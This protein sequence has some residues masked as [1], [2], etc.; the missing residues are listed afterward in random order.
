MASRR[1]YIPQVDKIYNSVAA[2]AA[3]LGVNA[4]NLGK[5]LS[6]KRKTAGGYS[7]IDASAYSKGGKMVTPNR[8]SLRNKAAKSGVY[9]SAADPLAAKR[10]ELQSLLI[11]TNTESKKIK[12][13]GVSHFATY[14]NKALNFIDDIGGK[15]GL[16]KTD[17]ATLSK[18]TAAELDKYIAAIK[19]MQKRDTFTLAGAMRAANVRLDAMNLT[20]SLANEYKEIMPLIFRIFD[21]INAKDYKYDEIVAEVADAMDNGESPEEIIDILTKIDNVESQKVL[22]SEIIS[23]NYNK[24]HYQTLRSLTHFLDTYRSDP[25][26]PTLQQSMAVITQL[27]SSDS[28]DEPTIRALSKYISDNYDDTTSSIG[29]DMLYFYTG[30]AHGIKDTSVGDLADDIRDYLINQG[31]MDV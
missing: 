6:G 20:V 18:L 17:Y 23:N 7:A 19:N 28:V 21:S 1:I 12:K 29:D 14:N 22:L 2:A 11:K 8:R 13:A 4:A 9:T 24:Y 5:T 26:D 15:N 25:N 16:Y 31:V 30:I 3:D 27:L 10:Q